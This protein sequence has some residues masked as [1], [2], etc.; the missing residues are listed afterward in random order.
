MNSR[1]LAKPNSIINLSLSTGSL[2]LAAGS[3]NS[4]ALA[5]EIQNL[6][7][8]ESV[9]KMV[10]GREMLRP[11]FPEKIFFFKVLRIKLMTLA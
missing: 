11:P 2:D 4:G 7:K 3:K 10:T 6:D 9:L 5:I 1:E 8:L